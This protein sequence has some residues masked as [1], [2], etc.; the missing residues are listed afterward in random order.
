MDEPKYMGIDLAT[1]PDQAVVLIRYG[2]RLSPAQKEALRADLQ[3]QLDGVE[4]VRFVIVDGADDVRLMMP[5]KP[6]DFEKQSERWREICKSFAVPRDLLIR[7]EARRLEDQP[8]AIEGE[9]G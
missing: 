7:N 9:G 5:V 8:P 6:S 3:R 4:G 2:S 1:G